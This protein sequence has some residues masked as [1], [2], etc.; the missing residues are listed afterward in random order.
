MNNPEINI[1]ALTSP[2]LS[3]ERFDINQDS[4]P[5]AVKALPEQQSES[6]KLRLSKILYIAFRYGLDEFFL[7]HARLKGL[8]SA[9]KIALFWRRLHHARCDYVKRSSA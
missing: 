8:R 6:P 4:K 9:V 5:E 1:A 7:A 2:D 3:T